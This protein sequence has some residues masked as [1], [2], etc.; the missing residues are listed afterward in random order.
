[1]TATVTGNTKA[2]TA[3]SSTRSLS[4]DGSH[5]KR[6]QHELGKQTHLHLITTPKQETY[7]LGELFSGAGGMVLGAHRAEMDGYGFAHAWVN[8]LNADACLTLESNIP[9][10]EGG[11]ICDDVANLNFKKLADIDGLAFGFPCNDFSVVG[12]RHGISGHYG[13]LYQ[14]GVKALRTKKPLFFVAE[15][16]SGIRSSGGKQDFEVILS[17]LRNAGYDVF[18]HIYRFEDYGVPQAR[19][20][21]II[22]GFRKDLEIRE[23]KHPEPTH[24]NQPKTVRSALK[25]LALDLPNNELTRQS[26][27]VQERLSYIKPGEN[28]FTAN[29]PE[30]LKLKVA[31]AT[32]SQIYRR[33]KPDAPSYTVTGSGGGGTHVYHWKENRALTNR[34]RARL[35][36]FPDSFVFYGGKESVRKQIGMAV[37]PEGAEVI[38][39]GVLRALIEHEIPASASQA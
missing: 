3:S 4:D 34:E 38:F 39:K 16:V 22:V 21:V 33:L 9:M 20:R 1:M 13:G 17:S 7:R 29:I 23:F 11:V 2:A 36:T 35:Q 12:D 6:S 5:M 26:K 14:W 8:D 15:N 30:R 28:A 19:H 25:G 18:P 24:A 10:P 31:G 32:I 27:D 37:P